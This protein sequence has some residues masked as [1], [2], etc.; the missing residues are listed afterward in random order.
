MSKLETLAVNLADEFVDGDTARIRRICLY[1]SCERD[2]FAVA[3]LM[4]EQFGRRG[5]HK[6]TRPE[7]VFRDNYAKGEDA[8]NVDLRWMFELGA[9]GG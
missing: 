8:Y 6:S 2:M 3:G 5:L 7:F 4:E 9:N 1:G